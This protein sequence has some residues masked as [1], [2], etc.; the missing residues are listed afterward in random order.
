MKVPRRSVVLPVLVGT[1]SL[2]VLAWAVYTLIN[3]LPPRQIVMTTGPEGGAYREF[4]ERYAAILARHKIQLVL[5]PSLGDVE[6]LERLQDPK[7]GVSVGFAAGGLTTPAKSPDI[8]SLGMIAN[9]PLWI[10]CRGISEA[11]RLGELKGKRISIGPEGSGTRPVVL[12]LL[13]ANE[14]E[15]KIDLVTLPFADSDEALIARKIDCACLLTTAEDPIAE[16]LLADKRVSLVHFE[17]ADAYLAR[18][19]HLRKVVVPEG[20]G[21]LADNRP[22][23]DVTLIAE[24]TS[25]VVRK[26]LHPAIQFLLLQAAD[27]VH[28]PGGILHRPQQFPA[29]EAVDLPLS[30]EARSF[31]RSGGNFLQRHLPFWLWVFVSRLLLVLIPLIGVIYPLSRAIPAIIDFVVD[32]RI[33][34]IYTDLRDLETRSEGGDLRGDLSGELKRLEKKVTQMRVPSNHSRALYTLRQHLIL[35]RERLGVGAP[36]EGPTTLGVA[37][38]ARS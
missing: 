20:V 9:Y 34:R 4:G 22:D 38:R 8:V 29:P 1:V 33:N 5:R 16:E 25:L 7:S 24:T 11:S 27:E 13:R 36:P 10:F 17:R 3:V 37:E 2:A 18:Y 19:R 30:D 14:L 6:N 31:Y 23:R 35:V 15:D 12:E 21:N 32:S 26:D 28:S